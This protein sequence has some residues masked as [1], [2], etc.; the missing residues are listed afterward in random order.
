LNRFS[1]FA[2]VRLRF[3]LAALMAALA[4]AV[5]EGKAAAAEGLTDAP[6]MSFVNDVLPVLSKAGCNQGT[7]HGAAAGKGNFKLS[8]RGFAPELDFQAIRLEELGRRVDLAVPE[9]SLIL[10]K[11]SLDLAHRGGLVLPSGSAGYRIVRA[12]LAQGAPPSPAG[13]SRLTGLAME[14]AETL[15]EPGQSLAVRVTARFSDGAL[16][17]VTEWARYDSS[18]SRVAT[19][20]G[21]GLAQATGP[22]KAAV[23]ASY[24]DQ[25]AA[26]EITVPFPASS[27]PRDYAALPRANYIDDLVIDQWQRLRLWPSPPADDATFLRRV[28]IDVTGTLPTP[29]E[30]RD[31]VA[32]PDPAK[33]DRLIDRLLADGAHV[34][35]W[36]QRWGDVFRVSREWLGERAAWTFHNYLRDRIARNVPWDEVVRELVAGAGDSTLL[37][38]PNFYRL[39][40]VYNEA[41]LWPLT[42]AE[43]TAQ[44][45]LGVR[46]QCARC[47]NHPFDRWTQ[48]DYYGFVSFFA[49]VT[50]KDMPDKG[51][52]IFDRATGEIDHPR[53]GRPMPAKALAGPQMSAG[54]NPW[55]GASWIWDDAS[56]ATFP[57]SV[58]QSRQPRFARR[59]FELE[60]SPVYARLL[61]TADDRYE[62]YVNGRLVGA[63]GA[64]SSAETYDVAPLLT[65]GR[66]TIAVKA[67]NLLGPGGLIAWLAAET[68]GRQMVV[69]GTDS[70]WKLTSLES[71]D[72][73]MPDAADASW[74]QALDLGAAATA[75]WGTPAAPADV[76][77]AAAGPTR[78]E[79]L[80]NWIVSP[81][82]PFFARAT[83]NRIWKH[84]F[85]RGLVEPVDD[86]RASNPATNGPLLDAL[87]K[88]L[89]AGGSDL[90]RFQRT[91][92]R[93]RAYQ[94]SGTPTEANRADAMFAS[95]Y[96]ARR[97][98]A[99]QIM[100]AVGHV[101]GMP[102]AFAGTPAGTR[103][104][105]LPDTKFPSAFLDTFGRPLRRVASCECERVQDPNL[106]Q[107]LEMMHNADQHASITAD[108]G[109]VNRLVQQGADDRKLL[110]EIYLHA[111]ARPPRDQEAAALLDDLAA[112]LDEAPVENRALLRRQFFE[113]VLWAVVNSKEF[114]FNH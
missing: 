68:A 70:T 80:A 13:E 64:W 2:T 43:T 7:C 110:D 96:L 9:A 37:G 87:A 76:R 51:V 104:Q 11:P 106:R 79:L 77:P 38:P 85:G 12:W 66:N 93:S 99:E 10:R 89:A 101:T 46:M 81:D 53:L 91:I 24:Q 63:D 47:H 56:A 90:A 15:L 4:V 20:D 32:D 108:A 60:G 28:A 34:D 54:R 94:L 52:V 98:T 69:V 45:F 59:S 97:M 67:V 105:Q 82:N 111:L 16:R 103:A 22:G 102:L 17:D 29:A 75:P 3:A 100:D 40:K 49:Q 112:T 65:A 109:L 26:S 8:L 71:P 5:V 30:V 62:V 27:E 61:V 25:V 48:A 57:L 6:R 92:L 42:A 36:A 58:D 55:D 83:A 95:H 50:F 21:S 44:T 19:V 84:Y 35:L 114:L 41:E 88:D 31:F 78:R 86:L 33:R 73:H 39:Q 107:A 1:P 23:S 18:D 113:D 14:P 72:W 74:P